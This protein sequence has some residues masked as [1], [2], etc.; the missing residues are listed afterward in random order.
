MG[1]CHR[2]YLAKVPLTFAKKIGYTMPNSNGDNAET[3][4]DAV[5]AAVLAWIEAELPVA[6]SRS[7]VLKV[8]LHVKGRDVKGSIQSFFG[9]LTNPD[10]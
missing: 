6:L 1:H 5:V 4:R 3:D 9:T 2:D 7:D 10:Q 8:E